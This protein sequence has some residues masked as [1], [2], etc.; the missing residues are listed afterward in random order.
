MPIESH[1]FPIHTIE[2]VL[3]GKGSTSTIL[4]QL[5]EKATVFVV[6]DHEI[7]QGGFWLLKQTNQKIQKCSPTHQLPWRA[8]AIHYSIHVNLMFLVSL[9]LNPFVLGKLIMVKGEIPSKMPAI[10]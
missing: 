8:V 2:V 4:G 5:V 7:C 9:D 6:E 10:W 1:P 3:R